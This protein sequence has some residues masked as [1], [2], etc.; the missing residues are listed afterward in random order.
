MQDTKTLIDAVKL[1]PDL[2]D[3][4]PDHKYE[5]DWVGIEG[6]VCDL[7]V[8]PLLS[9]NVKSRT[10][11]CSINMFTSLDSRK[12]GLHLSRLSEA[13]IALKN[14]NRIYSLIDFSEKLSFSIRDIQKQN[15]SMVSISSDYIIEDKTEVTKKQTLKPIK[16]S[17]STILTGKYTTYDQS[18]SVPGFVVCPCVIGLF[19]NLLKKDAIDEVHDNYWPSH[20]QRYKINV[21]ISSREKIE[22][23]QIYNI[24]SRSTRVLGTTLKRPDEL[25]LVKNAFEHPMFCEDLTKQVIYDLDKSFKT[26]N[27]SCNYNVSIKSDESIHPFSVACSYETKKKN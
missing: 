25:Y 23:G 20:S 21:S 22:L 26:K 3:L 8:K 17:I 24:L 13:L 4:E 15:N 16:V 18:I 11:L 6:L 9:E 14:S 7:N 12:K 1:T 27:I 2:P 19:K 10:L 5:L